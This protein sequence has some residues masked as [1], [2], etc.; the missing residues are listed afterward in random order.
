[1][2]TYVHTEKVSI[3]ESGQR[4]REDRT[5]QYNANRMER[6]TPAIR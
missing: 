5:G 3:G 2:Y 6:K 4:E 1:M